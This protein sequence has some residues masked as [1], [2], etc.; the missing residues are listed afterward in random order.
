MANAQA[1]M[2]A[3]EKI[4][5]RRKNPMAVFCEHSYFN[6]FLLWCNKTNKRCEGNCA[7]CCPD[8]NPTAKDK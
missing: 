4:E 5:Y 7:K 2:T 1:N 6:F 8:Y 3:E